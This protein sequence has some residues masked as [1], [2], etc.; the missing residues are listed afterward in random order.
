MRP[1]VTASAV[2][3]AAAIAVT[4]Q[5]NVA[6]TGPIAVSPEMMRVI[7][8]LV[9][10][11]VPFLLQQFAPQLLPLWEWVKKLLPVP[12]E[13]AEY[14]SIVAAKSVNPTCPAWNKQIQEALVAAVN[15]YHPAPPAIADSNSPN[16]VSDV[17]K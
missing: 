14:R 11:V 5:A 15:K 12:A 16:E 9:A 4:Q 6:L 3:T 17:A 1:V 8:P 10:A 2:G 7:L 13:V